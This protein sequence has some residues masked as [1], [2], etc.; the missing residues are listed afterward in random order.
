MRQSL[1]PR[2]FRM[3]PAR[4]RFF[5]RIRVN[6]S[7]QCWEWTGPRVRNG[8]GYLGVDYKHVYA[9]RFSYELVHGLIPDGLHVC[10]RCDNRS[11]CNPEH[12]FLGT[13]AENL[14]DMRS[15]GRAASANQ[16]RHP[17][18]TN[19]RAKLSVA[20]V[21]AIRSEYRKQSR[22]HGSRALARKFGVHDSLIRGIVRGD[23]WK[24]AVC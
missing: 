21:V 2:G 23:V 12:L 5:L 14:A 4:D 17:G 13:A 22:S 7:T 18:E 19:G 1:L 11:C 24:E 9:H 10:H 3:L 15:K 16:T 6:Q 8:Y 20:D